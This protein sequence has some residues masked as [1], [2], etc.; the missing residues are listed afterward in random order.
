MEALRGRSGGNGGEQGGGDEGDDS[1]GDSGGSEGKT[2]MN[3]AV[4]FRKKKDVW[5]SSLQR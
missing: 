3:E 1:D 5:A 4:F 2:P